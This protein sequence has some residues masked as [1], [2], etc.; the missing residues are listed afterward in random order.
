MAAGPDTQRAL[1]TVTPGVGI[2]NSAAL[3]C[4]GRSSA[5]A[6]D[7]RSSAPARDDRSSAPARDDRSSSPVARLPLPVTVLSGFLG[8]GK[9]TLL[10]RILTAKHG[11]RVAVIVNDMAELN[12]DAEV[13]GQVVQTKEQLV[14]MQNGC[15]CCTLR[16]DLLREVT[17]LAHDGSFDYLVIESTGVSEPLPVAETFTFDSGDGAPLGSVAKLDTMVTVVD[18][19]AFGKDLDSF[20]SLR[21]RS[22][23][24]DDAD[25]RTIAHLLV[26]QIEFANVIVM[27]K[28]D[29]VDAAVARRVEGVIR[30]LNPGAKLLRATQ[31]EVPLGD[32]LNTSRFSMEAAAK[33]PGWLRELRG[34]HTPETEEYGVSSFVFR[35]SAPFDPVRIR[36]LVDSPLFSASPLAAEA[37]EAGALCKELEPSAALAGADAAIAPGSEAAHPAGAASA[38]GSGHCDGAEGFPPEMPPAVA[39]TCSGKHG[40]VIRSKGIAWLAGPVGSVLAADWSHSGRLVS[41]GAAF[42]WGEAKKQTTIVVI[43]MAM[44][45][46]RVETA[47]RW[48]VA[49]A[50]E[51][52][53]AAELSAS[54]SQAVPNAG[55]TT[56]ADASTQAPTG[57]ECA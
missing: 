24:R 31:A 56:T 21:S 51:A 50:A 25:K 28:L 16:E 27:N 53:P 46:T 47:L 41:L 8:S 7:D 35:A 26:D 3:A 12:V 23:Q 19:A 42:R 18:T 48:A 15:I 55:T 22:W 44:D 57:G 45:A 38:N 36:A 20:E 6:R 17:R 49:D 40:M 9:T 30:G 43:G 32:V 10:K 4:D 34:E 14:S 2:R 5:P 37:S 13:A 52:S 33:A 11:L 39:T 54:R 1:G 29:L